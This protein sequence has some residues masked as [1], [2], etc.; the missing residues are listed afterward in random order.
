MSCPYC[1]AD[2]MAIK[3]IYCENCGAMVRSV[4]TSCG[5]IVSEKP[6]NCE[7]QEVAGDSPEAG[8]G[9]SQHP[10][11]VNAEN[12]PPTDPISSGEGAATSSC[13]RCGAD[14]IWIAL[15]YCEKCGKLVKKVCA[16]CGKTISEKPCKCQR[17]NTSKEGTS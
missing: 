5:K 15:I 12:S 11:E 1:G 8:D 3:L 2:H 7:K 17:E 13:P 9:S 4:C 16:A 14:D 6:C 10:P